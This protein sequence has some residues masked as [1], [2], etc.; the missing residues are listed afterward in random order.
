MTHAAWLMYTTHVGRHMS[1]RPASRASSD[2]PWLH[3]TAWKRKTEA[4]PFS[5]TFKDKVGHHTLTV[6]HEKERQKQCHFQALLKTKWGIIP[7]W[8]CMKKKDRSSAISG[9]FKGTVGPH[10]LIALHGKKDRSSAISGTF[11]DKV[12]HHTLTVLH[13]KEGRSSAIVRAQK[14]YNSWSAW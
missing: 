9:T 6:L 4:V 12:G 7:S 2:A 13:K 5:G 1:M 8:Y 10:T 3:G 14:I 11:K